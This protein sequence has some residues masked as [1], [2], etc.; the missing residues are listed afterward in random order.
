MSETLH[1]LIRELVEQEL[2]EIS[3]A[4]D[5]GPYKTPFAFRGNTASGKQKQKD[6]ST[7]AGYEMIKGKEEKA[8]NPGDPKERTVEFGKKGAGAL[9]KPAK[10]KVVQENSDEKPSDDVNQKTVVVNN[11]DDV[12]SVKVKLKTENRYTDFKS[13]EGHPRQKIGRAIR[14]IN[15][16]LSEIDRMAKMSSRLKKE[17]GVAGDNL[18][19]STARGLTTLENRLNI[20]ANRIR[21]LKI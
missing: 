20:I 9:K 19:K 15:K 2:E 7:Q 5:A 4:A 6:N 12:E 1:K 11:T 21:E 16:Q 10:T 3:V 8:D 18:W 14:E 17:A 13:A